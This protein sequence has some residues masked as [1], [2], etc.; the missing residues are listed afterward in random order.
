MFIP[1][2][3]LFSLQDVQNIVS[4]KAPQFETEDSLRDCIRLFD[5]FGGGYIDAREFRHVLTSLG[6]K[7]K[8]DEVD[9]I[10][11]EMDITGDNQISC[12][13]ML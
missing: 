7:L 3:R 4:T 2:D 10:T 12:D 8:D 9:E 13:G 5:K 6:E 11:R 1:G